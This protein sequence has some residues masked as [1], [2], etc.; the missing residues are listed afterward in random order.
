MKML[1]HA[2]MA[3]DSHGNYYVVKEESTY[4]EIDPQALA[5]YLYPHFKAWLQRKEEER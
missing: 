1:V 4:A 3:K 5:A 2:K